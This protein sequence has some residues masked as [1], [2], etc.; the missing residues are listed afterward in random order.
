MR[1]E[2]GQAAVASVLLVVILIFIAGGAVDVYRL[3]EARSWSYRT[4]EAA[5]L[6]GVTLGLDFSAVYTDGRVRVDPGV[7]YANAEQVLVE[8]LAH[9]GVSGYTYDIRVAE[10]GGEIFPDYP[11]VGRADLWGVSGWTPS[12]PA[13]G[14][15]LEVPVRTYILGLVNGNSPIMV[16][17]FAAAGVGEE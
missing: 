14:V 16:H 2:R 5:A 10:W 11:P 8:S 13:V 12:E 17:V 7:G 9:R 4:A 6:V 1:D 3:Q 15:Y